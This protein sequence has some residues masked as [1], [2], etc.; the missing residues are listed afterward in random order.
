MKIQEAAGVLVR[1]REHD[2]VLLLHNRWRDCWEYPGGGATTADLGCGQRTA[3]RELIEETGLRVRVRW[4]LGTDDVQ[5]LLRPTLCYRTYAALVN[6]SEVDS[7]GVRL[8]GEH[9]GW[10]WVPVTEVA[11]CP[12]L[13]P[14]LRDRLPRLL[15][16]E[17][18]ALTA[19]SKIDEDWLS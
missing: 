1:N 9:D 14:R 16:A 18:W 15:A 17:R 11:D 6:R 13:M 19:E 10:R 2:E 4:L 8:S 3:Q 12:G 5:R 7:V